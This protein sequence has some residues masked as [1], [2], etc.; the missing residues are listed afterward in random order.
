MTLVALLL[1][2]AGAIIFIQ[3]HRPELVV[4]PDD[5]AQTMLSAA[6]ES[7][8]YCLIG[9]VGEERYKEIRDKPDSMTSEETAYLNACANS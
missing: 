8:A 5:F 3:K 2:V 4:P 7:Q 6:I 1:I 9:A